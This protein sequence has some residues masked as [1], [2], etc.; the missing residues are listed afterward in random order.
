MFEDLVRGVKELLERR[1]PRLTSDCCIYKVPA[2][3]RK[4][5]E[6]A[7]T[8]KVVSIGP[9]HHGNKTLQNMKIHKIRFFKRFLNRI[10]PAISLENWIQSMDEL[11]PRIR[12]C[13][14][15]T[16]KLSRNELVKV[17]IVDAGFILEL[18]SMYY[19]KEHISWTDEDN[20]LSKPWFEAC[21]R[22]DLLLL[23]NQLPFFVLDKL[24]NQAFASQF[25]SDGINLPS[26][27]QRTTFLELTFHYFT[28]YNQQN[29][30]PHPDMNIRHFTD[31]VRIFH[32][33]PPERLP[34]IL[35]SEEGAMTHLPKATELEKVGVK[36]TQGT[37]KCLL[38]LKFEGRVLEVP[39]F[40]AED[41]TEILFR[42]IMALE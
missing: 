3:I 20:I 37:S 38:D 14:A 11:E 17:I 10:S 8:P 19:F 40:K 4:L 36:F 15:E 29:I 2:D 13:Y 5:N 27:L 23:E 25:M 33:P 6:D 26:F 16:I 34:N 42:N 32:L 24:F 22:S 30:A 21:I 7:Y 1:K 41:W 28:Y 39:C 35:Q 12:L 31:L 9:F 18:F